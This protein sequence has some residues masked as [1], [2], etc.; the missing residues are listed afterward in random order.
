MR[1]FRDES[2]TW[3]NVVLTQLIVPMCFL[4]VQRLLLSHI[5]KASLLG[6]GGIWTA[7]WTV[8]RISGRGDMSG[9]LIA[10]GSEQRW[11][12][13]RDF[14]MTRVLL[15][16][17][18]TAGIVISA[19]T[20]GQESASPSWLL[21][22]PH[23]PNLMNHCCCCPVTKSCTVLFDPMDC[24][25]PGFPVCPRLPEFAQVHVHYTGDSIQPLSSTEFI[26]YTTNNLTLFFHHQWNCL[27]EELAPSYL[28]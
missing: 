5:V 9:E 26:P 14:S 20:P 7:P 6:E 8:G 23:S 1:R 18:S 21:I 25:V 3:Q 27:R 19:W 13:R 28:D 16:S 22:F 12:G 4:G 15:C 17:I 2:Q 10:K 11:E 24:S